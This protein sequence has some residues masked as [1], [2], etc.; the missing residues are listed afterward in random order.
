MNKM[1]DLNSLSWMPLNVPIS[2]RIWERGFYIKKDVIKYRHGFKRK[3]IY[4]RT[5]M[6][7]LFYTL[8]FLFIVSFFSLPFYG[9][10][11]LMMLVTLL[12]LILMVYVIAYQ[13]VECTEFNLKK[14]DVTGRRCHREDQGCLAFLFPDNRFR[15]ILS[16]SAIHSMEL[17]DIMRVFIY[18]TNRSVLFGG[19]FV[20]VGDVLDNIIL[21][22]CF[23][24]L[25]E[26]HLKNYIDGVKAIIG[27][28]VWVDE[29][30][31]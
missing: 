17:C 1:R 4:W 18:N 13:R 2:T 11:S 21:L 15:V 23:G 8:I 16:R 10:M 22:G 29:S 5:G 14:S 31:K 6:G 27:R 20:L 19:F 28:E 7:I 26:G 9:S 25:E 3:A 24:Y 30:E 12:V